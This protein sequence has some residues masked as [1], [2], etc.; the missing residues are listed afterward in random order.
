[1]KLHLRDD[2][3]GPRSGLET[4]ILKI[5]TTRPCAAAHVLSPWMAVIRA[6][7][8]WP[9]E[10]SKPWTSSPTMNFGNTSGGVARLRERIG[11]FPVLDGCAVHCPFQLVR[12][13]A[14]GA[15]ATM[16]MPQYA[17]PASRKDLRRTFGTQRDALPSPTAGGSRRGQH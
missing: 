9:C 16:A 14:I 3:E 13:L 2:R 7:I 15:I 1:M 11:H 5:K 4:E 8:Q 6:P 17:Y 12:L 10:A